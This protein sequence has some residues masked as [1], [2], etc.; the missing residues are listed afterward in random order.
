M[1]G[2][3]LLLT[4]DVGSPKMASSPLQALLHS[5][6]LW[7]DV[8]KGFGLESCAICPTGTLLQ[9]SE[10]FA[11]PLVFRSHDHDLPTSWWAKM[12]KARRQP[13]NCFVFVDPFD[14]FPFFT[15]RFWFMKYTST[16]CA[17]ELTDYLWTFYVFFLFCFWTKIYIVGFVMDSQIV[18]HI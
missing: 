3:L 9:A 14:V 7:F 2:Q 5:N 16:V 11:L 8:T 1:V 6:R 18:K 17:Y 13:K 10:A 15:Y 4:F 12:S